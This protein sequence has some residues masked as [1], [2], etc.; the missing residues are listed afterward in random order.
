MDRE[1]GTRILWCTSVS[2]SVSSPVKMR[3]HWVAFFAVLLIIHLIIV[4]Y[5]GKIIT[6]SPA[7]MRSI[8][9][10]A[11]FANYKFTYEIITDFR[12]ERCAG[13]KLYVFIMTTGPSV[14][15]R[16]I[17]R[18]TWADKKHTSKSVVLFIVGDNKNQSTSE[19]LEFE[20]EQYNDI[21]Q[22]TI[23]DVYNFTAF[24]V[25]S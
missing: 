11:V 14:S 2:V 13:K 21:I 10:N 9:V 6:L 25:I 1:N 5:G 17:I 7:T 15:E 12:R 4:W 16:A 24:K 19:L 18:K 3:L 20:R 23:P 22:T 8:S